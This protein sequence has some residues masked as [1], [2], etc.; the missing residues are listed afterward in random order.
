[1]FEG[2]LFQSEGALNVKSK[3]GVKQSIDRNK[4]LIPK[5]I[6]RGM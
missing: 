6:L 3:Q 2:K 4:T 1:M 5:L